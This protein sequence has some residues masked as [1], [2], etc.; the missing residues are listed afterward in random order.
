MWWRNLSE[1]MEKLQIIQPNSLWG[2]P[3]IEKNKNL[4][5]FEKNIFAIAR[6]EIGIQAPTDQFLKIPEFLLSSFPNMH[7][8][9]VNIC[10]T[11][12]MLGSIIITIQRIHWIRL[13][14]LPDRE[15]N[16]YKMQIISLAD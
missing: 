5:K 4:N 13:A 6:E 12:N 2:S 16:I 1:M 8:I 3:S 10:I 15:E 7:N 9:F 14:Q 11:L